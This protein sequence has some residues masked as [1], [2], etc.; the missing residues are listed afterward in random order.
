MSSPF[1]LYCWYLHIPRVLQLVGQ[2]NRWKAF[3]EATSFSEIKD[4]YYRT[5][6][7][8]ASLKDALVKWVTDHNVVSLERRIIEGLPLQ[9][10][11]FSSYR[12]FYFINDKRTGQRPT[13]HGLSLAYSRLRNTKYELHI[14]YD[15]NDLWT[16]S[17]HSRLS[18]HTTVV[19]I[20]YVQNVKNNT[21]TARPYTIADLLPHESQGEESIIP[22]AR[23][24]EV[25]ADRIDNF[26]AIR[27][28]PPPSNVSRLRSI[29]EVELKK[30]FA[31]IIGEPSVP[32]DWGGESSDL[33]TT[34]VK[35]SGQRVPT[36]FLFKGPSQFRPMTMSALGKNGDQIHRLFS[37]P[38]DLF[39]LQHCH[40][41][42]T[43]V[44]GAM[45]A[46]ANQIGRPK[47]F[48]VIDGFDTYRILRAYGKCGFKK[49]KASK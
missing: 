38:A 17:A 25:S 40:S 16:D 7:Y 45:R 34:Y 30:A 32:K 11:V 5:V 36:A 20:G 23:Y 26:Q 1:D 19:V 39:I 3:A 6:A 49:P 15:R 28:V 29:P 46:Y 24:G 12:D 44:R 48:A 22:I 37:E 4:E 35:V 47:A 14:H 13:P 2:G 33:F 41:V 9:G 21:I 43:P 31:S 18:G 42:A 27:N 10:A 8:H